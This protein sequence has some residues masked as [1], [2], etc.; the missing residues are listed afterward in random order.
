[1]GGITLL[2]NEFEL[3]LDYQ[4]DENAVDNLMIENNLE[5][6]EA[7]ILYYNLN[8]KEKCRNFR[9]ETRCISSMFSRLFPPF[10]TKNKWKILIQCCEKIFDERVIT[11]GGVILTQVKINY[12]NYCLS[13]NKMKK[14]YALELLMDGIKKIT[15]LQKWDIKP[16]DKTKNQI[17][18]LNYENI[19][20]W[21]SVKND[22]IEAKVICNHDIDN[23]SIFLI[24]SDLKGNTIYKRKIISDLPDEWAYSKYLGDLIIGK[25]TISL[26]DKSKKIVKSFDI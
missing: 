5:Y 23:I 1:M 19:W 11:N 24:V 6:S 18:S 9:L 26:I 12:E 10:K 14:I 17:I 8:W 21:K 20:T 13:S 16:F 15:D 22:S 2:L 7:S 3:A 25:D 4:N